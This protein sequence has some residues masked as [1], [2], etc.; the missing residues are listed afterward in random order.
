M[1]KARDT[2]HF[3]GYMYLFKGDFHKNMSESYFTPKLMFTLK[4]KKKKK[5]NLDTL[6]FNTFWNYFIDRYAH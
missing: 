4:K 1:S 6:S 5:L 2:D 3:F